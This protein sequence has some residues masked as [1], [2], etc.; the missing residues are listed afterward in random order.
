MTQQPHSNSLLTTPLHA[1]HVELGAKM[2]P[3]AGYDMP[4][5]YP[6][7]V[8]KE[9]L[10]TRQA[11]GLFDV[12]HMGQLRLHGVDAA[13]AL[14]RLVPVDVIDLPVGKQR[15]AIFTNPQGGILDDLMVANL[16]DHLF[17]VVNAACKAQDIAHLTAHLPA[18]VH[19][20]VIEDR[21]LL[22]LQGPKAAQI[23]AQW[24]PAVAD[25]RFMDIQTLAINGIECIVSRSGYTGEDGFEIS[26]P[27]D[28]AVAFA[29]ALAEHSDVEWI[30][31]GARDSLRLECGLCLYGHDLD[32]TTTPVEAS[33]LWAIQPVRRIGGERAGGFPGAEIILKQIESKQV[34]RKRVG[35]VG[36][37]KAPVREGTEL[38]DSDGNKV[39]IVTSGT[40]GPTAEQPI[41]MGYVRANLAVIGHELFA[42]VRGKMLPMTIEKMPFVPQRYYRG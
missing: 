33:L 6:L 27:A 35:L 21:A 18:G 22:A 36:Q 42:E 9:H 30:G 37:T 39:G 16:G 25:M 17:L 12:S 31:L 23:L 29:Q 15:Y 3:F 41:S 5:Q 34:D 32:E 26:V 13:A 20:E 10:H 11:A 8:K 4:V 24:Q 40:V 14:E 38:F 2:V 28:K 7:G 1:V 19:L